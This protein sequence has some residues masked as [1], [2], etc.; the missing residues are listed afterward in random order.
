MQHNEGD[1]GTL[2]KGIRRE[3]ETPGN[4]TRPALRKNEGKGIGSESDSSRLLKTRNIE[5]QPEASFPRKINTSHKRRS[6]S[7]SEAMWRNA[8]FDLLF[9]RTVI[10]SR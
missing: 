6:Y 7:S 5:E 9:V 2:E 1:V 3:G 4:I 8:K 10:S